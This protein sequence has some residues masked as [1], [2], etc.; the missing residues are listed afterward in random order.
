MSELSRSINFFGSED[1]VEEL[2]RVSLAHEKACRDMGASNCEVVRFTAVRGSNSYDNPHGHLEVRLAKNSASRFVDKL[3]AE[4]GDLSFAKEPNRV[5]GSN[6]RRSPAE[7]LVA[8]E[9]NAGAISALKRV[10]E[11][12]DN[13][14]ARR[15]INEISRLERELELIELE[16][17]AAE[18]SA[19]YDTLSVSYRAEGM[20]RGTFAQAIRELDD[21]LAMFVLFSLGAIGLA[22]LLCLYFGV[23]GFLLLKMRQFAIRLGLLRSDGDEETKRPSSTKS[24]TE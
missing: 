19:A 5:R 4:R 1:S 22:I 2:R 9:K 23:T 21:L 18:K 11:S 12:S 24:T 10:A 14:A 13:Y 3:I 16:M 20:P 8:R 15:A 7:L 6:G 17:T